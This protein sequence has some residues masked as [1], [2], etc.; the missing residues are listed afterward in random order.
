MR[1]LGPACEVGGERPVLL[2]DRLPEQPAIAKEGRILLFGEGAKLGL[3][4]LRPSGE[5][6]GFGGN[7][8]GERSLGQ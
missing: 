6:I 2:I 4:L 5:A 1:H 8:S 3:R 7:Q